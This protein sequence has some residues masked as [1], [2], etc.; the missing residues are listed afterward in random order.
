MIFT[1]DK[2]NKQ[3]SLSKET[4]FKSHHVLERRD[5]EKWIDNYPEILGEE[6]LIISNEYDKFDKT[7]ERLDL[8]AID[9]RGNLV[10]I[11]LKRDD[12]GKTHELQAIKYAAY[13][14]TLT[15]SDIIPEYQQYLAKK[16]KNMDLEAA[17]RQIIGFIDEEFE[18][19]NDK[20]RIILVAKEYQTEVTATVMW[21]RKFEVNISCV[22]LTPYEMNENTLAF[23][24][25]IIIPV[26]DAEEYIIR[27]EK[28]DNVTRRTL[29]QEEYDKFFAELVDK[30][31]TDMPLAY[32]VPSGT[33]YYIIPVRISG[34]H[35]EWGF[36]GK[37]RSSF[38]V[39]LHFEKGNKEANLEALSYFEK[40]IPAIE[41]STGEQ[42][43][44]QKD[45]GTR[46]SRMYIEK[47]EGKMTDELKSWAIEKMKILY[48]LLK[49]EF[50]KYKK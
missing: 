15:L 36:H 17:K 5:I 46:W 7:S 11:E 27:A 43:V 47:N 50:D 20:P 6:L 33:A 24:S 21:L 26:P 44:V 32:K 37:P 29:S 9:K 40:F 1:Y 35:L 25:N 23:E 12:S 22:K 48:K 28:K 4:D 30:I 39:E 8:L 3:I 16:G 49:P 18:E 42:V 10:V 31:K 38:G 13:C 2:A 34:V 14:S 19:L 45:W 41:Q